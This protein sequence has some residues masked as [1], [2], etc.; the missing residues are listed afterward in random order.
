MDRCAVH[1]QKNRR[2]IASPRRSLL[3]F[4]IFCF[5]DFFIYFRISTLY[6]TFPFPVKQIKQTYHV[7]VERS[8]VCFFR[9]VFDCFKKTPMCFDEKL[10]FEEGISMLHRRG[11]YDLRF[12]FAEVL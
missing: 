12:R 10:G 6:Q 1:A 4:L 8:V 3:H 5:I 11:E 9:V 2:A 7:R